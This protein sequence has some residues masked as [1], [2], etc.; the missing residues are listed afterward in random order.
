MVAPDQGV[1]RIPGKGGG[2]DGQQG[3][4]SCS[5]NL[6]FAGHHISAVGGLT[7]QVCALLVALQRCGLARTDVNARILGQVVFYN[8]N[9]MF[10]E[11]V[12]VKEMSIETLSAAVARQNADLARLL[13]V[14]APS[15]QHDP[16]AVRFIRSG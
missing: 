4:G 15:S 9:Q 11:F 13:A 3:K 1:E 7:D 2:R 16:E 12:K 6:G 5:P 8:L 10:I 14:S